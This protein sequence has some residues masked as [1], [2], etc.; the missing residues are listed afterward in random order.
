MSV[1]LENKLFHDAVMQIFYVGDSL[2]FVNHIDMKKPVCWQ[3]QSS[4]FGVMGLD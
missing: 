1:E 3:R 2:Q 4:E